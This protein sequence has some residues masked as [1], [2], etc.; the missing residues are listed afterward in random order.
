MPRN[1]NLGRGR[2]PA[3]GRARYGISPPRPG[4][5]TS[6][7]FPGQAGSIRQAYNQAKRAQGRQRRAGGR[8]S[9]F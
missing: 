9:T 8:G 1:V 6:K 2:V 7:P 4:A 3:K 5:I